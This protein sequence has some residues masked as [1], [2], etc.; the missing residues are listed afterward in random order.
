MQHRAA[1]YGDCLAAIGLAGGPPKLASYRVEIGLR[2]RP[3]DGRFEAAHQ[4]ERGC[5]KP[6]CWVERRPEQRV[7]G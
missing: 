3:I 4:M 1:V 2:A 7:G 5:V 6:R